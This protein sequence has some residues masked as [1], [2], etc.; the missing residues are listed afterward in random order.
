MYLVLGTMMPEIYE[1]PH[2]PVF[3]FIHHSVPDLMGCVHYIS[4]N[5]AAISRMVIP[6]AYISRIWLSIPVIRVFTNSDSKKQSRSRG[7]SCSSVTSAVITV[8]RC[9]YWGQIW[10]DCYRSPDEWTF[11]R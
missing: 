7:V 6:L 10:P 4:L 8:S 9:G 1:A 3:F 2:L 5:A 11:R